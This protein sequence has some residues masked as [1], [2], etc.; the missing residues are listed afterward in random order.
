MI[1]HYYIQNNVSFGRF[2]N[3]LQ[4]MGPIPNKLIISEEKHD[5]PQ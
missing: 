4:N 3:V 1:M 2:K 5:R